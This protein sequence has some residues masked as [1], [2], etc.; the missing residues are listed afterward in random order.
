[1]RI[2]ET[3]KMRRDPEERLAEKGFDIRRVLP[4]RLKEGALIILKL[5]VTVKV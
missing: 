1:L 2:K 4:V 3:E 5:P